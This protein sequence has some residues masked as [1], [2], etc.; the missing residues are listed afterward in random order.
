M[1]SNIRI[2]LINTSHPGN[3]GSAARAMKTMGLSNLYLVAPDLFP[4]DK[5]KEMASSAADLLE[6]AVVVE[7]LDEAI[8]DC[9]LVLGTSARSRAIPWPLLSP[10][11]VA[12]KAMDEAKHHQ[13]ALLFGREQSGLTNEELQLCHY[14][15]H[16]PSNPEYSSLNLSQAVQV[17]AYELRVA[18]LARAEEAS[19]ALLGPENE[20]FWDFRRAT[21]HEMEGFYE[22]LEKTLVGLD[23][24]DPESPRKLMLRM[25]RLYNRARPDTMELN[26]LRGMLSAVE[27]AKR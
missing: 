25:R 24:L 8:G 4:H 11:E 20:D 7:T 12:S 22:H 27:K 5:A 17:L 6:T 2:V 1:F 26:I 13:V 16:I 18:G 3:I 14:H 21:S 9:S 23:F 10:R 19:P 15:I